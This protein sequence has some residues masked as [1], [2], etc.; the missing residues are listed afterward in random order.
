MVGNFSGARIVYLVWRQVIVFMVQGTNPGMGKTSSLV[1]NVHT[2][3]GVLP[4]SYS[5]GNGVLSR[6]YSGWGM[7][8]TI[9]L[10][11]VLS[12]GKNE[13]KYTSAP[14]IRLHGVCRDSSTFSVFQFTMALCHDSKVS[15]RFDAADD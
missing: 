3:S 9:H 4:A 5:V 8:L 14:L 6:G 11:L 15:C 1:Q 13:W 2:I 7:K 10:H 12:E